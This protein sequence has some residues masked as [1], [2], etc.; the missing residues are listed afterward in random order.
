MLGFRFDSLGGTADMVGRCDFLHLRV[1][2]LLPQRAVSETGLA[3]VMRE[4]V[5]CSIY[6]CSLSATSRN[7]D[8]N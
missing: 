2:S 1:E 3:L 6:L 8:L 4:G 5:E 7:S